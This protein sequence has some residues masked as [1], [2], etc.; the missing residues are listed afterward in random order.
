VSSGVLELHDPATGRLDAQRMADYL[1]IPLKQ[2]SG[3]LRRNYSTVH[4]TPASLALQPALRPIERSLVILEDLLGDRSAAL[5][6]LNRSHP[7]LGRRT[8]MEVILEGHA[9]VIE[10]MLDAAAEGIPS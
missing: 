3:A 10:N 9:Q 1:K 5:I 2:L 6:W 4:K 8:P 7:D